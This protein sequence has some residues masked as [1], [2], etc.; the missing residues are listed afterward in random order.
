MASSGYH[1]GESYFDWHCISFFFFSSRRRHTRCSRDWSSNV[2]SSDLEPIGVC[3]G[4][5]VAYV[6][7]PL[8]GEADFAKH[9]AIHPEIAFA[10]PEN[11][12]LN[13][14]FGS[15]GP[16]FRGPKRAV[17]IRAGLHE[18]QEIAVGY[19][20]TLDGELRNGHFF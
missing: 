11:G 16:S 18:E 20:V 8:L 12:M 13:A 2:C 7:G 15:P 3:R 4:F 1:V 5:C 9:G 17:V 14:L 19:V 10:S 6:H